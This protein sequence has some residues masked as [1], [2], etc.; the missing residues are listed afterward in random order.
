METEGLPGRGRL[1][2]QHKAELRSLKAEAKKALSKAK[3]REDKAATETKYAQLEQQLLQRQQQ[4]LLALAAISEEDS[5][6]YTSEAVSA[7]AAAAEVQV[8]PSPKSQSAEAEKNAIA[9][10]EALSL[11]GVNGGNKKPSKA[12][13]RREKKQQE[14]S[15][16]QMMIDE[17]RAAVSLGAIE[18]AKLE[19]ALHK[20]GFAIFSIAGD[21]HCLFR[22]IVHQLQQDPSSKDA[23]LDVR[24]LRGRIA[25][26][27]LEERDTF[28]PFLDEELQQDTAYDAFCEHIRNSQDWGG[29]IEL[30]AT[31]KLLRRPIRVFSLGDSVAATT[32]GAEEYKGAAPLRLVFH[33][34]LMAAG[35]HYNSVIPTEDSLD[36]LD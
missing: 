34:H 20:E 32:Y 35:P 25:D 33:R 2:Q 12:R 16:R 4:Q 17:S 21:G 18:W 9:S 22:S 26:L 7:A 5:G 27:M 29:E 19:E 15:H 10:L 24:G 3:F 13:R 36:L 11:Y 23:T 1:L 31:S 8:T 14:I 30:H 6:V 28:K